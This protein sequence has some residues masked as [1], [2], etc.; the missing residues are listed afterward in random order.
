[1]IFLFAFIFVSVPSKAGC[2]EILY[3]ALQKYSEYRTYPEDLEFGYQPVA[4]G[5]LTTK[6]QAAASWLIRENRLR[7][8]NPMNPQIFQRQLKLLISMRDLK[9]MDDQQIGALLSLSEF[10][11]HER[12]SDTLIQKFFQSKPVFLAAIALWEKVLP[13]EPLPQFISQKKL[14][15]E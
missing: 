2:R 14:Q 4:R 12:Y 11:L 5:R 1:M 9:K 6:E 3:K 7:S 13:D 8:Q 15:L 10:V